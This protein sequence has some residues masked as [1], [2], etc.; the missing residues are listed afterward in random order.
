MVH[1]GF[2]NREWRCS[3]AGQ[4]SYLSILRFVQLRNQVRTIL[5]VRS[6]AIYSRGRESGTSVVRG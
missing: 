3:Q 2:Y 4:I 6:A 1:I 5:S